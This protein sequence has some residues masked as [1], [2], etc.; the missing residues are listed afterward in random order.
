MA[1]VL[2]PADGSIDRTL[3]HNDSPR[4]RAA[5]KQKREL[6]RT[7]GAI[8]VPSVT[9]PAAH[10]GS[11]SVLSLTRQELLN[12]VDTAPLNGRPSLA[13]PYYSPADKK[14][15]SR[16][17]TVF[18]IAAASLVAI[19]AAVGSRF[20]PTADVDSSGGRGAVASAEAN[21]IVWP[22]KTLDVEGLGKLSLTRNN[23]TLPTAS[24]H[25]FY[26][27][28]QPSGPPKFTVV[29]PEPDTYLV[30]VAGDGIYSRNGSSEEP[31]FG[32]YEFE[33]D[34]NGKKIGISY[35]KSHGNPS[36]SS[37]LSSVELDPN[38]VATTNSVVDRGTTEEVTKRLSDFLTIEKGKI[39]EEGEQLVQRLVQSGG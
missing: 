38:A 27:V 37:I 18:G 16:T 29:G 26:E 25:V 8:S 12:I 34:E 1:I 2:P 20:L 6:A 13:E 9:P 3:E 22:P 21:P 33:F 23:S 31:H 7:T 15:Q 30:L 35:K 14:S 11:S 32:P 39:P 10:D 28:Y 19:G 24:E 36:A 17:R 5:A 4:K